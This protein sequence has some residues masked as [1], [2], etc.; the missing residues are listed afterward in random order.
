MEGDVMLSRHLQ[1][2]L[3]HDL[4]GALV[5]R[6]AA[7]VHDRVGEALVAVV[8]AFEDVELGRA[9]PLGRPRLRLPDP[10]EVAPR[11]RL[12]LAVHG[13]GVVRGRAAEIL[14]PRPLGVI[15]VSA[16]ICQEL[17]SRDRQR[18]CQG[19]GVAMRG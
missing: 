16:R 18:E 8:P 2:V 4:A 17:H 14:P 5:E 15:G 1:V 6:D 9:A 3:D 12:V 13:D 11:Q 19:I 7:A 10:H